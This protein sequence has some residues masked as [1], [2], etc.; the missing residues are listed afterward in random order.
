MENITRNF[1]E[2]KSVNNLL[3]VNKPIEN[4]EIVLINPP[5]FQLNKFLYKKIGE[6]YNWADRLTWTDQDWI[7]Y[8]SR[9]DMHTHILKIKNEIAGF[10]EFIF[11]KEKFEIEIAYLGLLEEYIGKKLGGYMLSEAIKKSF[12]FKI[13]RVWL[14]TCSLDNQHALKNYQARGMNVFKREILHRNLI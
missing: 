6:K 11:H 4:A 3:K 2:I 9:F 13:N 12:E 14:H 7:K 10:F 1:L 8:V 5:D